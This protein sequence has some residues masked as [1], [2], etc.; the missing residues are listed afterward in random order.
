MNLTFLKTEID[1]KIDK[2]AAKI[3]AVM[4]KQRQVAREA[5]QLLL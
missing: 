1:D 2:M 5:K 4:A 3:L